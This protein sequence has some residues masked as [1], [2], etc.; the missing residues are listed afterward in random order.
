MAAVTAVQVQAARSA[1][2]AAALALRPPESNPHAV[3]T[4]E[5]KLPRTKAGRAALV[6]Q[7]RPAVILARAWRL[8]YQAGQVD[9]ARERGLSTG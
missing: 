2:H 6:E 7:Q 1:G 3:H 8:G 9:Y 4:P 5:W